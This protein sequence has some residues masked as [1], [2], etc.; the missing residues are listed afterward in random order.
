MEASSCRHDR[1]LTSFSAVFPSQENGGWSWQFQASNY[2]LAFLVTSP[3][4]RAI[5]KPIQS[6]F[7]RKK[8][9]PITQEFQE[10]SSGNQGA[11]T[12]VYFPLSHKTI[13]QLSAPGPYP[14]RPQSI[15][16]LGRGSKRNVENPNS[17]QAVASLLSPFQ[18]SPQSSC[19]IELQSLGNVVFCFIASRT[20]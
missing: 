15:L 5:Q 7:I 8:D 6:H 1:S 18:I 14:P 20:W 4:P 13:L 10:P 12:K 9:T 2:G 11:E 19:T 3:H 16:K 17:S